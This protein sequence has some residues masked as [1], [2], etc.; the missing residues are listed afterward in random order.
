MSA[1]KTVYRALN[2][3]GFTVD[4]TQPLALFREEGGDATYPLWLDM[5]DVITITLELI[6]NRIPVKADRKGFLDSLLDLMG[7]TVSGIIMDGTAEEGYVSR[8]L[9]TG[10]GRRLEVNVEP[11][12]ALL[13]A[14]RYKLQVQISEKAL[15]SSALIDKRVTLLDSLGD[16]KSLLGIL[17]SLS[18]EEMGKYPV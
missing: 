12:T 13:T 14:I 5:D 15:A 3:V 2:L 4:T 16:D 6:T 1:D 17:E 11:A 9:L 7:F 10:D 18:P 8:I